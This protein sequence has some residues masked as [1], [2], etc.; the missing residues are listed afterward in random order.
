MH[1]G[2]SWF[3]WLVFLFIFISVDQMNMCL[4]CLMATWCIFFLFG[5]LLSLPPL[6]AVPEERQ[7]RLSHGAPNRD[8]VYSAFI[9]PS[10]RNT[11]L[12]SELTGPPPRQAQEK[13]FSNLYHGETGLSKQQILILVYYYEG[14]GSYKGHRIKTRGINEVIKWWIY[15]FPG[16]VRSQRTCNQY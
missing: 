10:L 1:F 11:E 15:L 4:C 14:F 7:K 3:D 13:C 2:L 9:L 8:N 5:V 12:A 16:S 6:L